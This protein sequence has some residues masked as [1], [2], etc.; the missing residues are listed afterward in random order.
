MSDHARGPLKLPV[1]EVEL[2]A[3][4][5]RVSEA[6]CLEHHHSILQFAMAFVGF[7]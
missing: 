6:I 7:R 4:N 1:E 3:L 2:P 5:E